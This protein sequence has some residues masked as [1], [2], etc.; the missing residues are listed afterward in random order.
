MSWSLN[1]TWKIWDSIVASIISPNVG[2]KISPLNAKNKKKKNL[3]VQDYFVCNNQLNDELP[4]PFH[5]Q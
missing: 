4:Q 1:V 2:V 3:P 5:E